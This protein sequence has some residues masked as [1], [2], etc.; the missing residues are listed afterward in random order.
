M[1]SLRKPYVRVQHDGVCTYGGSQ[2]LSD[3]KSIRTCG[4]GP[5]AALDTVLYLSGEQEKP[6][7]LAEYNKKLESICRRYFPLL[8]PFGINGVFL[9]AGMNQLLRKRGLP[10]RASW[11]FSGK[12]FFARMEEMLSRDIPVI[13]SV[14]PNF[15]A[16]WH[17]N[18]LPFYR[19]RA[20]GSFYPCNSTVAHY[21]TATGL[22]PEWIR[23][24]SWGTEY[25]IKREEYRQYIQKYSANLVS[26][27]LFLRN[28]RNFG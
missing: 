27:V 6:I 8:P 19:R 16:V 25:Y 2:M 12:K 3:I 20:D 18:K 11:A 15:P 26:N 5:V 21:V 13:F 14:G 1:L 4:C 23:I 7:P 9:A 17:K 10:Y 24:S 28:T 22:D